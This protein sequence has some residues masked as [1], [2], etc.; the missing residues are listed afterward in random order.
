VERDRLLTRGGARL[1][2]A[3]C[4]TGT[5]G[6]SAAGR[7]ALDAGQAGEAEAAVRSHLAP[8]PRV[9]EGQALAASGLVTAMMDVSDGVA[10]D[11]R[12]ICAASDVGAVVYAD[13]LPIAED[14]RGVASSLQLDLVALA[15]S[16]GEDFELLFTAP[17]ATVS[18]LRDTVGSVGVT[19]VGEVR[20]AAEG[21]RLLGAGGERLEWH[22]W[23]HFRR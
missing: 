1:C 10:S 20:P 3:I 17:N 4:V 16:G 7:A 2:D 6:R 22:G 9:R 23:D 13:R 19:V 21:I 12:H 11:L 14:T 5:L 18:R 8:T 15:L